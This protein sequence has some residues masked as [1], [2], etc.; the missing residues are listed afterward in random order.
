MQQND[1]IIKQI[2]KNEVMQKVLR[3]TTRWKAGNVVVQN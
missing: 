3:V 2:R 1:C